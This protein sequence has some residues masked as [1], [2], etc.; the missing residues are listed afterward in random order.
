MKLMLGDC[1]KRMREISDQSVDL[2]LD[3]V[4]L[5]AAWEEAGA[6]L[7]EHA[8]DIGPIARTAI[9]QVVCEAAIPAYITNISGKDKVADLVRDA[10]YEGCRDMKAWNGVLGPM[11]EDE[12]FAAWMESESRKALNGSASHMDGS[13]VADAEGPGSI[14]GAGN[15]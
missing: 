1:L 10:F 15:Q 6:A 4:A 9:M 11:N 12:V 13:A 7:L 14:P 2:V 5:E 3:R 8:P